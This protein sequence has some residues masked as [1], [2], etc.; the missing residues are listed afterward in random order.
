MTYDL[1]TATPST[2]FNRTTGYLIGADDQGLTGLQIYTAATIL[3]GGKAQALIGSSVSAAG[4]NPV[5]LG[6]D[7]VLA[8]Y[9]LPASSLIDNGG[10]ISIEAFGSFSIYSP[11]NSKRIRIYIGCTAATVGSAVSGGTLIAD[12]GEVWAGNTGWSLSA[13]IVKYGM[14][15]SNTQFSVHKATQIGTAPTPL[16]API[17]LTLTEADTAL[18][19]VTGNARTTQADIVFNVLNISRR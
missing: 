14:S 1:G 9:T 8:A 17:A 5:N 11:M 12:S 4:I 10:G 2:S 13:E 7:N 6:E 16:L 19:A 18:I 15:G 3:A